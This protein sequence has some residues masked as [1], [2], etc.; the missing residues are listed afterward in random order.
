MGLSTPMPPPRMSRMD[1]YVVYLVDSGV[2]LCEVKMSSLDPEMQAPVSPA[3][4][5]PIT[6]QW[7][8]QAYT[9]HMGTCPD[10]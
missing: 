5:G 8:A 2:D 3:R 1:P 7:A 4:L 9:G 10:V 6:P